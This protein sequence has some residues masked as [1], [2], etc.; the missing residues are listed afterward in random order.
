[1]DGKTLK[2]QR[3]MVKNNDEENSKRKKT[4][5]YHIMYMEPVVFITKSSLSVNVQA[6]VEVGGVEVS[7]PGNI[8]GVDHIHSCCISRVCVCTEV[9]KEGSQV[10]TDLMTI[11]L[12]PLSLS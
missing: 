1:M 4:N 11:S 2:K 6:E 9:S 5:K 10:C 8:A 3:I 12:L 7:G